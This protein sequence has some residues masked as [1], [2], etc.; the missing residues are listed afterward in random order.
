MPGL[1]ERTL[2]RAVR[3]VLPRAE[4]EW[5]IGD[6]EEE[7]ARRLDEH[8]R[9]AAARWLAAETARNVADAVG[10]AALRQK[11]DSPMRLLLQDA[12]YAMRLLRRS[13]GMTAT[14]VITLALGI[15]A[16]TAIFSVVNA[17][18]FKP[19]PY[20]QAERLYAVTLA[21]DKPRGSAYWP[22]PKYAAFARE[23]AVFD[24]TAAYTTSRISLIADGQPQRVDAETVSS[25]YFPIVGVQPVLGRV[26]AADEETVPARDAVVVLGDG[27]WRSVFGADPKVL[28]RRVRIKDRDYA[29][30]GVMPPSFR[31]QTGTAQMWLPVMMAEHFMYKG[32]ATESFSWWMRVVARVRPG[33][34][35]AAATAQMPALT[36]RV[37][38]LAPSMMK[39]ATRDGKELFQLVPFR[40]TKVDP[41]VS[42]AFFVLLAAVGF[43][44][45]IA[46]ANTANLLLGRAVTRQ[47][48]FAVRSA[49]GASRGA[50]RRQVLVESLLLALMAGAAAMAVSIWTLNWLSSAKPMNAT[51]FWTQYA[52]TF[53][54]FSVSLDPRVAAFNFAVALGVGIVF[55][56]L[57]MRQASRADLNESLKQRPGYAGGFRRFNARAG[58]VLAEIAFSI[59]LLVS[60]GLMIRSFA[61]AATADLGFRPDGLVTMTASIQER[62][63]AAFYREL[64]DRM[65]SIPGVER[66]A[67]AGAIP[68]AGGPSSGPVEIE[69]RAKSEPSIRAG[70][71]VVTPGFFGTFGMTPVAG[72]VLSDDDREH[73]PRVAVVNRAFAQ[74]AWPGQDPVGKRIRH[75]FRVAFGDPKAWTTIVG[76]VGDAVYGMLEDPM[77]PTIYLPSGQPLGTPAA[78]AMAPSTIALRTALPAAS[79]AAAV[80][81]QLNHLDPAAPIYDVATMDERAARV[82][83]R[84]RYSSAMMGALAGLALLLAAIGTYG[85]IAYSVAMRTRE[86]GIRVALGARPRDVLR[87]VVGGGLKLTA[88]GVVLGLAGAFATSRVLGNMLYGVTPHD[89]ATFV[90]IAVLMTLVAALASYL[91]AARAMAVD[92]AVALRKD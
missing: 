48:E 57:P 69:G 85:V 39:A 23:Q 25:S 26:F 52:Q 65:A 80:R 53:D 84:Y 62:R 43:V 44:L 10:A 51:G 64:L 70:M 34:T 79:V 36:A 60:A 72:R 88:A 68:L 71:N 4:R 76:V 54:Y 49:L 87:L 1:I 6:L 56:L 46:C 7:H 41:A 32:A 14:I 81:E 86:I 50:I 30:V 42:R 15:G 74:A 20:P 29:V 17:L 28:G 77:E 11:G 24:V 22:Y 37:V 27:L 16:N 83:A 89:P 13:P 78:M 45:L 75:V 12:R 91:P 47:A 35:E 66:A 40:D 92:P 67:L 8:G 5:M 2:L 33:V 31:G 82:T 21:N 90:A 73:T 19:L 38:Q 9:S 55:A 3:L 59:V 63:P 58:L 61:H 18:L